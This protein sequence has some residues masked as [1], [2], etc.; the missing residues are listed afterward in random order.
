MFNV[1]KRKK[2][3]AVSPGGEQLGALDRQLKFGRVPIDRYV[4][5]GHNRPK[6]RRL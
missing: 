1:E 6:L 5:T 2:L 4:E 3:G